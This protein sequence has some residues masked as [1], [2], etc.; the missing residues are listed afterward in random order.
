[1]IR[2]DTTNNKEKKQKKSLDIS[3]N[4]KKSIENS[5]SEV[6][7][8]PEE[9]T[10]WM[11][12][13][14]KMMSQTL[15]VFKIVMKGQIE[16]TAAFN[17]FLRLESER[18]EEKLIWEQLRDAKA[19]L[20]PYTGL[21][22][23]LIEAIREK[24]INK[25]SEGRKTFLLL[26]A[27]E[28]NEEKILN[29]LLRHPEIDI[30]EYDADENTL[31]IRAIKKWDISTVKLLLQRTGIRINRPCE[32]RKTALMFAIELWHKEIVS[33]LLDC[34]DININQG[35]RYGKTALMFAAERGTKDVVEILLRYPLI[36]INK[37]DDEKEDALM[38]AVKR[39]DKDIVELLLQRTAID[40]GWKDNRWSKVLMYAL[41]KSTLEI[42]DMLLQKIRGDINELILDKWRSILMRTI[43]NCSI[44][45]VEFLLNTCTN[46]DINR[47]DTSWSTALSIAAGNGAEKIIN[48]LLKH[49]NIN[50]N[51]QD[52]KG[53]TALM[54]NIESRRNYKIDVC[55]RFLEK[56]SNI[57]V[58][59]QDEDGYTA[60][61]WATY[62][63]YEP[64][65]KLLLECPGIDVNKRSKK[66]DKTAYR[67][68]TSS[69]Y[70]KI[71]ALISSHKS[72]QE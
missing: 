62:K 52:K 71:A 54:I 57:D 27:Y 34:P 39:W 51:L 32:S 66:S 70:V 28:Q 23:L 24:D 15:E 40:V 38:Y 42:I 6:P 72:Y 55:K 31:L 12:S 53:M 59:L 63:W 56:W 25:K 21:R 22:N 11:R 13:L 7:L 36:D 58:N 26:S 2:I 5:F 64:L 16:N 17:N 68:A 50:V 3:Q 60:L 35:S 49:P 43:A 18:Y 44:E 33:L 30:N 48:I 41:E 8:T 4:V 29:I 19:D 69:W 45:K 46:I 65:V 47:Q 14:E 1:M 61:M 9:L 20:L 67:I 37:Q 10:G